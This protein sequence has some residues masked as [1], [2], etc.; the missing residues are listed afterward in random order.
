MQLGLAADRN[1]DSLM[2]SALIAG[3]LILCL[4]TILAYLPGLDGPFLLDDFGSIAPLG[5]LGGV[6]DWMTFKAS[7]SN[8]W[9]ST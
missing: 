9:Q 2:K 1:R 4:V 5:D 8:H 3:W 7:E 6:V